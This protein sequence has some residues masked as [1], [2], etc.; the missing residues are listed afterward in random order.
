MDLIVPVP[1][2]TDLLDISLVWHE[3]HKKIIANLFNLFFRNNK[4]TIICFCLSPDK[5]HVFLIN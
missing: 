1:E 5:D 4:K 3:D 2:F